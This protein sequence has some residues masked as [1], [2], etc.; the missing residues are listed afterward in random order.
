M[1][2]EV[3]D[4][5]VWRAEVI[6]SL[7]Q[8][9]V[10]GLGAVDSAA[11]QLGVS[12]RR[13]YLLLAR[14]RRGEGVV[15][16]MIPGRS[17]GGRRGGRLPEAVEAVVREVLRREYLTRQKKTIAA[18]CRQITRA[19]RAQGLQPPS[20]GAVERRIAKLDP[21]GAARRREGPDAARALQSAGGHPPAVTK[22][23]EQVQVDHTVVDLEVVDEQH[24][25]PIG[26]PY[27]TAGIDVFSRCLVGLVVTLEAPAA[28]SVGLCLAHMVTD[29]QAWLERLGVEVAWPMSGKPGEL[30]LDNAAELACR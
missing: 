24:R 22:V 1:P 11:S 28:T 10:V 16:E 2:D 3:W 12:R 15:S 8:A 14:W 17:D 19:C 18:V 26:R 20:R 29:K 21:V 23:L 25:L 7:A 30:Y 13:V 4:L 6:D 5:A 27:V 9:D